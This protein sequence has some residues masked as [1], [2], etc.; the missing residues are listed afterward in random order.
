VNVL[1]TS[2]F[3]F[4]AR[5]YG[6]F[7]LS[8]ALLIVLSVVS[9]GRSAEPEL[10]AKVQWRWSHA[11]ETTEI[12]TT[13]ALA[14]EKPTTALLGGLGSQFCELVIEE[15][16]VAEAPQYQATIRMIEKGADGA[17]TVLASPRL[18]TLAGQTAKLEIGDLKGE[19]TE[20]TLLIEAK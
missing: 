15:L 7:R 12:K 8:L 11:G 20:L 13:L 16:R 9:L 6:M 10:R 4:I 18:I 2:R 14:K 1:K 5:N 19:G 17:E 3:L